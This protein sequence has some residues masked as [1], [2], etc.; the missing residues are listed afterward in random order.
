MQTTAQNKVSIFGAG[1][2]LGKYAE[3][4]PSEVE[5]VPRHSTWAT[6]EDGRDIL[7]GISTIH[8]YHPKE[9]NPY[10][11]IETNLLHFMKVL[12]QN[13][14]PNTVFNL[15]SSWFVYGTNPK[16]PAKEDS[17]C[18]P[19]GFYSITARTRE[20]LLISYCETFGLKYRIL[21]LGNVIGVG[22]KKASPKKNALQW[23]I[24]ELVKGNEV[25][26]YKGTAVRDYIDVRDCAQAI[27]L[28][29]EK[30]ATNQ[31]YNIA[32]G[33]GLDVRSLVEHAWKV[34]GY[35][36]KV[37]EMEVPAFHQQVQTPAIYM[38]N[39]KIK[40]L[41]YS[42]QHDIKNTIKELVCHYQSANEKTEPT[43][44]T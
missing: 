20:Q 23:M 16:V 3:M 30:G 24:S 18:N 31:I 4:Y 27:H 2:V 17:P 34:N 15:V 43:P 26:V 36:G 41:G 40:A 1:F 25:K 19:T 38:D 37:G 10:I 21:R 12:D 39:S 33:Q 28:I 11:D 44:T 5:I 22:D 6:K 14:D 42:Q 29:L 35:K 32:N 13:V 8:N 9:G 7:Y